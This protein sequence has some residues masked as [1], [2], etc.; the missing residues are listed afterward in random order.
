MVALNDY[1]GI[2][3]IKPLNF[4]GSEN[5]SAPNYPNLAPLDK[6]TFTKTSQ[7]TR[8]RILKREDGTIDFVEELD[9]KTGKK[10][11]ETCYQNDGKTLWS[12]I[13]YD[14]KTGNQIKSTDFCDDGVTVKVIHE[15]DASI[16][17]KIIKATWF[18]EDGTI[19]KVTE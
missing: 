14:L 18:K 1:Y 4:R 16:P 8:Q 10:I 19:D 6:D 13:Q 15:Y 2:Q 7:P 9:A 12:I 11:K 17:N 5:T 3:R